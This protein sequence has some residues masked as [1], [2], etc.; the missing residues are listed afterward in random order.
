LAGYK[1]SGSQPSF[2][3]VRDCLCGAEGEGEDDLGRKHDWPWYFGP[4][5]FH[6]RWNI[7][8]PVRVFPE[9]VPSG[10]LGGRGEALALASSLAYLSLYFSLKTTRWSLSPWLEGFIL[11]RRR[12]RVFDKMKR[13]SLKRLQGSVSGTAEYPRH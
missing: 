3:K 4:D 7:A 6:D 2:A 12:S 1:Q 9:I 8:M 5:I 13:H 10:L 11:D